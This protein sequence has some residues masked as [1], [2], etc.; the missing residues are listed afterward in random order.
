MQVA[1]ELYLQRG[2]SVTDNSFV[3]LK[4]MYNGKIIE[5]S[6]SEDVYEFF[7]M[8]LGGKRLAAL[9]RKRHYD[10]NYLMGRIFEADPALPMNFLFIDPED[11]IK[12]IIETNIWLDPGIMVQDVLLKIFS[13]KKE[14]NIPLNRPDVKT[15]WSG[16]GTFTID[17]G[18]FIKELNAERV[19]L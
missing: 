15:D 2:L 14:L 11:D 13:D 4:V 3:N 19:K 6:C 16:R 1:I 5:E 8:I 17:I 7:G 9:G 10:S 12:L 18:E